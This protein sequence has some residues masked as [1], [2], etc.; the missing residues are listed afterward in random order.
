MWG[1][2]TFG[3][4]IIILGVIDIPLSWFS[5]SSVEHKSGDL[6]LSHLIHCPEKSV[7]SQN[8]YR[9]S[10]M[11]HGVVNL[12]LVHVDFKYLQTYNYHAA[13]Q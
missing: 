2:R 7:D 8:Q 11:A 4:C 10:P 1:V 9:T 13:H 6:S 3:L 5:T 12:L